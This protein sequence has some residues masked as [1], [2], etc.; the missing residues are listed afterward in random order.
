MP[1]ATLCTFVNPAS[2]RSFNAFALRADRSLED[3]LK[4]L[5][6]FSDNYQATVARPVP[7][8]RRRSAQGATGAPSPTDERRA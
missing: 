5:R 1:P 4:G 6:D 3:A 8:F 2:W 7:L